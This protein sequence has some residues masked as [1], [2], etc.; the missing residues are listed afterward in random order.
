MNMKTV[1]ER[2]RDLAKIYEDRNKQY[3]DNYKHFGKVMIGMFPNGL[4]LT[5]PEEFNRFCIFVQCMSKFTRYAN[6]FK[7]GGHPDSLDDN[8]VYSMMLAEYDAEIDDRNFT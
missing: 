5:T 8:A 1:P 4:H 3:K 2:L 7:E 6:M